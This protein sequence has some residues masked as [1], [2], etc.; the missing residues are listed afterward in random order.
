VSVGQEYLI[1]VERLVL[2]I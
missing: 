2:L 1:E